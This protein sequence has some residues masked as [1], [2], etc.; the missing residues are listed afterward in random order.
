MQTKTKKEEF[1][2]KKVRK[3]SNLYKKLL[4]IIEKMDDFKWQTLTRV[5]RHQDSQYIEKWKFS[6][7]FK[8]PQRWYLDDILIITLP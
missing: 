7:H 5:Y 8:N 1:T 2:S 4:E 3:G 6:F